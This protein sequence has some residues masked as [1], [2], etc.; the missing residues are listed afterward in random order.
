MENNLISEYAQASSL[1]REYFRPGVV[2]NN[3][4]SEAEYRREIQAGALGFSSWEGGLAFFRRR[5]GFFRM[6]FHLLPSAEPAPLCSGESIVTEIPM[7]PGDFK[8][9]RA[10]AYWEEQGFSPCL[11]RVRLRLEKAPAEGKGA[12]QVRRADEEELPR[13]LDFLRAHFSPLT[14]CLPA[15]EELEAQGVFGIF[16]GET[17]VGVLRGSI[18]RGSCEIRHLAVE[19]SLRG[20]GAAQVLL[21]AYLKA[22]PEKKQLVWTGKNNP[23]ALRFYKKCGY[24]PDGW[25]ARILYF[26]KEMKA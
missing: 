6:N 8:M 5:E 25:T 7:R 4:M 17:P 12:F 11:E 14:G 9:A 20:T 3:F 2:T 1:V 18:G 26:G 19:E 23:G 13:I 24:V 10:V 22:C 16:Q 21:S 15:L